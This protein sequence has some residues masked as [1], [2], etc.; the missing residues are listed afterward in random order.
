VD[1]EQATLAA[2]K[3][4]KA[5]EGRSDAAAPNPDGLNP[6]AALATL[7]QYYS[8][9][10]RFADSR[11][12]TRPPVETVP[13]PA[14]SGTPAPAE[15]SPPPAVTTEPAGV[16]RVRRSEPPAQIITDEEIGAAIQKGV[17]W[18]IGQFE[19]HK[20]VSANAGPRSNAYHNGMN[21]LCVYSL[22]QSS[23]AIKD[24]RLNLKGEFVRKLISVMKETS[25]DRGP[26][27][28]A[29]AL[30]A[31]ALALIDRKEDRLAMNMDVKYLLDSHIHG[32][33]TYQ[34]LPGFRSRSRMDGPWDN[35]NSQYGLLGV[36]SGAEVGAEVNNLYWTAVEQHW[37]RSQLDDGSWGYAGY[38]ESG[39]GRLSMAVAGIASLFVTHDYLDAPKFGSTVGRAPFSPAL[40]KG[41]AWLETDDRAVSPED[42]YTLYGIERVG[43]ASGFKFLGEYDWY[44]TLARKVIGK[45]SP[46][47]SWGSEQE[48]A[49]AL[50]FLARGRHPILMNKLRF[51]GYWA[52]R[53]RDVANLARFASKELERPLNWQVVPIDRDWPEWTDSPILSIASHTPPKIA[54]QDLDK[55]R[56]FVAAG[57]MLFT[58]ADGGKIE[59]DQWAQELAEQI[60]KPYVMQDLPDDHELYSLHYR[61]SG[62]DRPKLRY[63][64]NGSRVLM[65]HS[66]SDLTQHW[67]L[68][69]DKSKRAAF[70]LG[71]NLFLYAAGKSDLRNRLT[72]SYI[73]PLP[74]P[75][76][77]GSVNVV[78]VR[79][80]G[81]WNPE[82]MAWTRFARYFQ[83]E[84]DVGINSAPLDM[85]DMTILKTHVPTVA[86]LTGTEAV[87]FTPAQA[88]ALRQFV[89]AGGVL[90]VDACGG[91]PEFLDSARVLIG[92]AFPGAR[93]AP[94]PADDAMVLASGPGMQDVSTPQ[95]RPYVKVKSPGMVGRLET[96]TAGKGRVIVSPLDVTTGMLGGNSWGV[97]G[98]DPAYSSALMKNVLLWAA[99]STKDK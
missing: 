89:E 21:A 35:S 36:W 81:N 60:F 79:Y 34:A 80:G 86:H 26:V 68:R 49:Y 38:G 92:Q 6:L 55:I 22:L 3:Q 77:G 50:L 98:F 94:V 56:S 63:V 30:R 23:Y 64:T 39:S 37:T 76:A 13:A 5:G 45:Q 20:L 96:L 62:E 31:T 24:E 1:A 8:D 29:R 47:G 25:M 97:H 10:V 65:V 32:A 43:L 48:T 84:T 44:R 17:N 15:P 71:V 78:R 95:L 99:G 67:Q 12:G 73:P 75:P 82:P 18:M 7:I 59:M 27:T 9:P 52:N 88:S 2:Q 87:S 90:F 83:L 40:R 72:S 42:G 69:A 46:D 74:A 61:V 16:L 19:N 58:Q 28:Y 54:P 33:Y 93:L 11:M 66:P 91:G 51:E 70:E 85:A 41:L 14:A 57:G 4:M 53:P